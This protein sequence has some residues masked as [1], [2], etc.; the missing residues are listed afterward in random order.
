MTSPPLVEVNLLWLRPG[1]VGGT[2]TY[3]T[4]LLAALADDENAA[5]RL[6]LVVTT[7]FLAAYPLLGERFEYRVGDGRGGRVGRVLRE[8]RSF[9]LAEVA[10]EHHLGSTVAAA[11]A[12]RRCVTIYDLQA[13]DLPGY[14]HP[15]KRRFL[16]HAL[17]RAVERSELVCVMSRW[18][19]DRLIDVLGVEPSRCRVVPPAFPDSGDSDVGLAASRE[20]PFLLYPAVTWPHKRHHLVIRVIE[21]LADHDLD[22]VLTGGPG[23]AHAEVMAAI[24]A[25]RARDRIS[26]LG[27]VNAAELD[28]LYRS[29]QALVMPS[30]YE[31]FGQ[32]VIEAMLR[33]CPVVSSGHGAL[34]EVVGQGGLV[35]GDDID[36][37]VAAIG[38]VRGPDR[39]TLVERGRTRAADFTPVAAARA[40]AA[41]YAELTGPS[42]SGGAD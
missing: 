18:V 21:R 24:E 41:V 3:A 5:H 7:E 20:R 19:A 8:R 27:R 25:S 42:P 33:G 32:P 22:L 40:Q 31:G 30:E 15:A 28:R 34:G 36:D 17:P 4:E 23:P 35:V 6:R 10:A 29:A 37:W 9:G 16:R 38:R 1:L 2:E 13:L 14:F 39:S 11:G 26:H 12:A